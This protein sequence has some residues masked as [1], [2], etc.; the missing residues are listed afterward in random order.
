MPAEDGGERLKRVL[1]ANLGRLLLPP[2]LDLPAADRAEALEV[3]GL[4][5]G[6]GVLG[7]LAARHRAEQLTGDVDVA[8]GVPSME[9]RFSNL[10]KLPLGPD[11]VTPEQKE[12]PA[13]PGEPAGT[14]QLTVRVDLRPELATPSLDRGPR[15]ARRHRPTRDSIWIDPRP[16]LRQPPGGSHPPHHRPPQSREPTPLATPAPGTLP[17]HGRQGDQREHQGQDETTPTASTCHTCSFPRSPPP[18]PGV[19]GWGD[20]L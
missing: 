17:S 3:M 20:L 14:A 9:F 8:Q 4:D 12:V 5:L 2:R 6:E 16:Q 13:E 15:A 10:D 19:G 1:I 18:R 7:Q 11:F